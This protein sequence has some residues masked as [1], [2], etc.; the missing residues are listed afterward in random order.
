MRH[1]H[2]ILDLRGEQAPLPLLISLC[3]GLQKCLPCLQLLA[4]HLSLV[5]QVGSPGQ[6]LGAFEVA[7]GMPENVGEGGK[8][9]VHL[10]E[11]TQVKGM[12]DDHRV[13]VLSVYGTCVRIVTR[14][15]VHA[16]AARPARKPAVSSNSMLV[17]PNFVPCHRLVPS[18]FYAPTDFRQ[19]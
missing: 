15:A 16:S 19:R 7:G 8:T 17:A 12:N 5:L 10:S 4:V 13:R 9:S 3:L 11:F 6:Q 2:V 18:R 14:Y 1:A